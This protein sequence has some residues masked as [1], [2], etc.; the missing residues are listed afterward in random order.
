M[1]SGLQYIIH[2]C[3]TH[4]FTLDFIPRYFLSRNF[5][6][7]WA[8]KKWVAHLG[9]FLFK[10]TINRYGAFFYS[11]LKDSQEDVWKELRGY[12]PESAKF[13]VL[14]I[15]FDFMG[16]GR[17]KRDFI[18][19][20]E[21]LA[22]L[23]AK[24]NREQETLLPFI[25]VDPRRKDI[26][27]LVRKYIGEKSFKGIKLYPALGFYP[28]DERLYPVYAY[29]ERYAIPIT[30][31]C[32]PKNKNHFRTKITQEMIDKA[33]QIEGYIPEEFNKQYDFAKYLNHPH[34]YKVILKSFPD[35]KINLAH[36][37]GNDE[38]D[39][40][41]DEPSDIGVRD[42]V[43]QYNNWYSLIR[44]IL[45]YHRNAYA[46]ISFTVYDRNLYPLLKNLVNS[47]SS[48]ANI[49]PVKEKILFGTDFYMLQKDY[50]ERRFGIDLRGYLS[51]EEYWLIAETNPKRFLANSIGT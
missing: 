39:K 7:E 51:D 8:K 37:G 45:K 27:D 43:K 10:N 19:Q 4:L 18:S 15:D 23:A 17:A 22:A 24:A 29:A 47:H 41:L 3:H 11:A 12:Y 49:F 30:T 28:D 25:C 6:A 34:W 40:Y 14:S 48:G 31:H 46:D 16:A 9:S 36:F 1:E 38:W 50:R 2:N 42:G 20:L 21:D 5:P 13:C 26:L 33:K 35:L 44:D 32:I